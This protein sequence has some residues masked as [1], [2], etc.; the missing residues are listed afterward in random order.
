MGN[1]RLGKK[2]KKHNVSIDDFSHIYSASND[3]VSDILSN[4]NYMFFNRISEDAENNAQ[5]KLFM[6]LL[7]AGSL[8]VNH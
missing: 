7:N 4:K 2:Q 5:G 6:D 3:E 8:Y 1:S